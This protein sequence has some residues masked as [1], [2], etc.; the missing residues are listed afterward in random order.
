MKIKKRNEPDNLRRQEHH[1]SFGCLLIRNCTDNPFTDVS[2]TGIT[3]LSNGYNS[4]NY[5]ESGM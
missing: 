5:Q 3:Y 2:E 4:N 1:L